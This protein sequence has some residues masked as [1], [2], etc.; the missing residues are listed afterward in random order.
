MEIT[1]TNYMCFYENINKQSKVGST[2]MKNDGYLSF[3]NSNN[4]LVTFFEKIA[5]DRSVRNDIIL[6]RKKKKKTENLA[7]IVFHIC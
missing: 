5:L 4:K 7:P 1:C 6:S 3:F 2:N